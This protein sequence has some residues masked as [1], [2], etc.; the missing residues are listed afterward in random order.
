M[1]LSRNRAYKREPPSEDATKLVIVCEGIR[2]EGDYFSYFAEMDSRVQIEVVRPSPDGDNSPEG[3]FH[4]FQRLITS[5]PENGSAEL[6]LRE[7]DQVWFVIDTDRWADKID[8]LRELI[9]EHSDYFVVQSN[10]CFEVWLAYHFHSERPSFIGC[11]YSQNW[12]PHLNEIVPGGF[13]SRTHPIH[14][15]EAMQNAE[16][17]FERDDAGS[18][19]VGCTEVFLLGQRIYEL[20]GLKLDSKRRKLG[21]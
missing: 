14:L 5:H 11:D 4:H 12:K 8:R 13:D 21:L 7:G 15:S 10:P 9:A 18:P 20:L 16:H 6:E 19:A 2:R 3:L 17:S 1:I